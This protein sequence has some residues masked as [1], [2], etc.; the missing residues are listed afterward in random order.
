MCRELTRRLGFWNM[1]DATATLETPDISEARRAIKLASIRGVPDSDLSEQFGIKNG[2]IRQWRNRDPEW[3]AAVA[4][5][6]I[7][8]TRNKN[9]TAGLVSASVGESLAKYGE[10][11]NLHAAKVLLDLILATKAETMKPLADVSDLST[12]AKTLRTVAGLDKAAGN[13]QVSIWSSGPTHVRDES[14][15]SPV[16]EA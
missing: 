13:V 14:D 6:A 3:K 10:K 7:T 4:T 11:G 2:T 1:D 15:D 8:E 12:A 9:V 16:F 5:K